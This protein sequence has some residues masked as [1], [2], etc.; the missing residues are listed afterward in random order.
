MDLVLEI[1]WANSIRKPLL[2]RGNKGAMENQ[3]QSRVFSSETL[4]AGIAMVDAGEGLS[5]PELDEE[6]IQ[7]EIRRMEAWLCHRIRMG[8]STK[9]VTS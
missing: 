9:S 2:N 4:A 8:C 6:D 1:S 5:H 7:E 3:F